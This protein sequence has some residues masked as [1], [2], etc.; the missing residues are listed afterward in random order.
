[1]NAVLNSPSATQSRPGDP[2]QAG[3]LSAAAA[4]ANAAAASFAALTDSLD[5]LD[6]VSI[7][8]VRQA[9]RFADEAHLGPV[10]YTHL[11]LPTICSV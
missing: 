5:Y 8:Q 2:S 11:T 6:A 10:S 7:E 4:A 1:M 9:Y 3:N